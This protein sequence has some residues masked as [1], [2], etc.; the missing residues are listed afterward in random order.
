MAGLYDQFERR[1]EK[2]PYS[3]VVPSFQP[4]A[5][6]MDGAIDAF[7]SIPYGCLPPLPKMLRQG[8]GNSRAAVKRHIVVVLP[9][10]S[11]AQAT[12]ID[13]EERSHAHFRQDVH[14]DGQGRNL[15]GAANRIISRQC[16][17]CHQK[18]GGTMRPR[19]AGGVSEPA[20]ASSSASRQC[21]VAHAAVAAPPPPS[22]A[23][24]SSMSRH[25]GNPFFQLMNL[26]KH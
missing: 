2:P 22:T 21:E 15:T 10:W 11:K 20:P 19:E 23:S 5:T 13:P 25:P 17:A 26:K 12:A 24:S 14:T 9:T 1:L 6:F 18:R 4:D 3:L 16:F 7:L 8:V